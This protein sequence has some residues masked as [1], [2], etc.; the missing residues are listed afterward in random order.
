ME[1]TFILGKWNEN[2]FTY[3]IVTRRM[4]FQK[5]T[6]PKHSNEYVM[7]IASEFAFAVAAQ[8]PDKVKTMPN[9]DL[10]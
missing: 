8:M 9:N 1:Q 6:K 2:K 10:S 3:H 5:I 4:Q 7:W